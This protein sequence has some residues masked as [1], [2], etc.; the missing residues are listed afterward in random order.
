[1]PFW[2]KGDDLFFFFLCFLW[3]LG[4]CCFGIW[5]HNFHAGLFAAVFLFMLAK[6]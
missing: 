4:G 3:V 1:M 2:T 6:K 5:Q